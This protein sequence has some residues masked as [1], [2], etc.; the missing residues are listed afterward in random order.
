MKGKQLVQVR[1]VEG[2]KAKE[3]EVVRK[4]VLAREGDREEPESSSKRRRVS[5]K[6]ELDGEEELLGT[7]STVV[8]PASSLEAR[9]RKLP[10]PCTWLP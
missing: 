9:L 8:W 5:P 2:A 4:L 7:S 3:Q 10:A 6:E 1:K